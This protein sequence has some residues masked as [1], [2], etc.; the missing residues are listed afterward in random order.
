MPNQNSKWCPAQAIWRNTG[1]CALG[2]AFM[3]KWGRYIPEGPAAHGWL[4]L[5]HKQELQTQLHMECQKSVKHQPAERNHGAQNTGKPLDK[6]SQL[7]IPPPPLWVNSDGLSTICR[8]HEKFRLRKGKNRCL[9][10]YL[11]EWFWV[12]FPPLPTFKSMIGTLRLLTMS[13]MF[14][15]LKAALLV[16]AY[17]KRES[18]TCFK[19][20]L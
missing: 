17:Q 18:D 3:P 1:I 5:E 8:K 4:A 7:A 6:A 19:T 20:A 15:Q 16:T 12:F 9:S 2:V 13:Q 10:K 11:Y 14:L